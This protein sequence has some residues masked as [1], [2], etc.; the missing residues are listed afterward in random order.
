[1][2]RG[3]GMLSPRFASAS[4]TLWM[5]AL[6]APRAFAESPAAGAEPEAARPAPKSGLSSIGGINFSN[7][8]STKESEQRH[9]VYSGLGP[10]SGKT[11]VAVG[12]RALV[13]IPMID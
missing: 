13:I 6:F 7:T 1:M 5:I 8:I 3:P 11:A 12:G 4:C 2:H 9:F 10:G